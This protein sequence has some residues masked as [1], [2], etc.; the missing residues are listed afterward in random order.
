MISIYKNTFDTTNTDT[1]DIDIF[2]ENIKSGYYAN[3]VINVRTAKT[4]EDRRKAKQHS[5]VVAISGTFSQKKLI[6]LTL[7][8]Q[9]ESYALMT[10]FM[11]LLNPSV[12]MDWQL[13]YKL[14]ENVTERLFW[15]LLSTLPIRMA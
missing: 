6:T 15:P 7:L 11:P 10:M 14:T 3:H 8:T 4:D 5:P 13:L 12:A 2:L 9:R 1:I